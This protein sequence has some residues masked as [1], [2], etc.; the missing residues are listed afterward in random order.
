MARVKKNIRVLSIK[1]RGVG[2][3]AAERVKL[4]ENARAIVLAE[5]LTLGAAD[6]VRI[7]LV[8]ASFFLYV[9][10]FVQLVDWYPLYHAPIKKCNVT[11]QNYHGNCW[12]DFRFRRSHLSDLCLAFGIAGKIVLENRSTVTAEHGFLFLLNRVASCKTLIEHEERWGRD[13]SALGRLYNHMIEI[14]YDRFSHLLIRNMAWFQPRFALYNEKIIGRI[15]PPV[16]VGV[17]SV[18]QFGDATLLQ[19][20]KPQATDNN[21]LQL[22]VYNGKD[23]VLFLFFTKWSCYI[24]LHCSI[25]FL[26]M[27][28]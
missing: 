5:R 19:I 3:C 10:Q 22:A 15:V 1:R 4:K 24:M 21:N 2:K 20:A 11:I 12:I 18:G 9:D 23:K 7:T 26:L 6:N 16:P 28:C 13:Y 17:I 14:I 27:Y 8:L 25:V